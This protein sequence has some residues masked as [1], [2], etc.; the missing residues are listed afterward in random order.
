MPS[1]RQALRCIALAVTSLIAAG[2]LGCDSSTG[3][4][5]TSG[6]KEEPKTAPPPPGRKPKAA[7]KM[8]MPHL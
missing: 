5:S 8:Q 1:R 3:P 4:S 7:G 6:T 2:S